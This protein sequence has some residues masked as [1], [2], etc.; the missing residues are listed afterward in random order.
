MPPPS[1]D[2]NSPFVKINQ[3]EK[4]DGSEEAEDLA[5]NKSAEEMETK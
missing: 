5:K 3:G 1:G 2:N 4:Q